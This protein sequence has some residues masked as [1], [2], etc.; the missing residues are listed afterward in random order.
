MERGVKHG[1][2]KEEMGEA[3]NQLAFYAGWAKVISASMV[4]K[5]VYDKTGK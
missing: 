1:I 2:T 5:E 4:V 3:L